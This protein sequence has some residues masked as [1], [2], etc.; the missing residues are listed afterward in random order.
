MIRMRKECPEVGWGDFRILPCG[1]R[2]ALAIRYEWR[3]NALVI[4]HNLADEPAEIALRLPEDRLVNLH[5]EAHSEPGP[6]K[7]H[8]IALEP[9]GYRWY[10]AGGLDYLLRRREY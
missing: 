9:Y 7:A 5:S 2:G 8:R 6:G 10:R 1:N 4:V 3:E